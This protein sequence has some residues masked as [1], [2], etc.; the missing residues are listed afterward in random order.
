MAYRIPAPCCPTALHE[1]SSPV[2]GASPSNRSKTG[3]ADRGRGTPPGLVD[4]HAHL[5]LASP[6]DGGTTR[7]MAEASAHAQLDAGVLVIREPGGPDHA[8]TGIGPAEGLPRVI[9]AGRFLAPPGMYFPGLAREVTEDAL[10]DA[11]A[12]ELAAGS[13]W[14]KLIG[15]FPV[16]GR[17]TRTFSTDAIK[18]AA[19]RVHALEGRI[20]IHAMDH[21]TIQGAIAAGFDSVEQDRVSGPTRWPTPRVTGW[22]GRRPA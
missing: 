4:A 2:T 7:E 5:A 8:S 22:H 13:G 12:D 16:G 18:A 19:A 10:P 1:R 15:D 3:D 20:A 14:V 17:M 6:L 11:A 9:T 21:G